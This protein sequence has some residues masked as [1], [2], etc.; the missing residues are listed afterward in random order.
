MIGCLFGLIRDLVQ[1]FFGFWFFFLFG[2][3]KR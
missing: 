2:K 3:Q 1:I